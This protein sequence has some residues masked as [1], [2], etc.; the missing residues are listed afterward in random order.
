MKTALTGKVSAVSFCTSAS[1][2]EG[3]TGNL[4]GLATTRSFQFE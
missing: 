3:L 4:S 2:P 1:F